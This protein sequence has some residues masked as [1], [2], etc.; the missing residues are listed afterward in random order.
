MS[1]SSPDFA[2][3]LRAANLRVTAARLAVLDILV[4]HPHATIDQVRELA[5]A[6]LGSLSLQATYDVLAAL[7]TARLIRRV[8]PAGHAPRYEVARDNHHHLMCRQCGT[9]RDVRCAIGSAP[10]LIPESTHG[11]VVDEAEVIYWGTCP[12]CI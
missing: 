9:L 3:Q 12:D 7:H 5:I 11:F 8:E 2:S 4:E 10:C 1:V 6:R